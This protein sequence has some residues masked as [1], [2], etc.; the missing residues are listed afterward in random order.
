M[1]YCTWLFHY[2][3][4]SSVCYNGYYNAY[5]PLAIIQPWYSETE[6]NKNSFAATMTRPHSTPPKSQQPTKIVNLIDLDDSPTDSI[7]ALQPHIYPSL[8][9]TPFGIEPLAP[10]T[11]S[12]A[13]PISIET[14]TRWARFSLYLIF[15]VLVLFCREK[16]ALIDVPIH[17]C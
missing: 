8:T 3:I 17:F 4:N 7:P 9:A 2:F 11:N 12:A 1:G 16:F 15:C 5:L 6:K 10:T 13:A 14:K